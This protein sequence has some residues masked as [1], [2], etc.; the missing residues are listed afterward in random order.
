[1]ESADFSG[2]QDAPTQVTAAELVPAA[3]QDPGYCRVQG[4]V[5]PQIGFELR[6][7]AADWNGKF[8]EV[9]CGGSCG[10]LGWTFWCPLR[11][12]YACLVTDM[13]HKSGP[14][15]EDMWAYNNL[16]AQLDW[17][18][19][20]THVV[21]LAGR[22]ITERY[23]GRSPNKA[24]FM[25]CSTGGRQALVEAQRF[26]WDFDGI[27]GIAGV[28]SEQEILTNQIWAVRALSDKDGRPLL[29]IADLELVHGAA[30]ASGP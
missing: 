22:T 6:L 8:L 19:R 26:P 20:S 24:Y 10:D 5:L 11:R 16:Q 30:L 1:L 23:Y 28:P 17:G 2:I 18:S 3:E 21:V 15:D 27:I 9:G 4:Y 29:G 25:G 14:K 7:P 13:G 12:G